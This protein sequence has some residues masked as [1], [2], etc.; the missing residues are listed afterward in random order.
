MLVLMSINLVRPKYRRYA[1]E[2]RE[3]WRLILCSGPVVMA[4][5]LTFRYGSQLG[6]GRLRRASA[7]G[8]HLM[9]GVLIGILFLRESFG[10]MRL[11]SALFIVCGAV[12]IR[13]S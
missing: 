13:F 9:V 1:A 4:S 7:S 12:L 11:I 10:K 5:F 2:L 3:N 6:T 8:Q